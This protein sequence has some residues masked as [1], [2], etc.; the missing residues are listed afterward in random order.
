VPML[1]LLFK[2][3]PLQAKFQVF[4]LPQTMP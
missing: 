4:S 1:E 2:F 3:W